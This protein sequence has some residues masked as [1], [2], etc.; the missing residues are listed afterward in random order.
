MV[1]ALQWESIGSRL[2]DLEWY[3]Q[4]LQLLYSCIE[5]TFLHPWSILGMCAKNTFI[6]WWNHFKHNKINTQ[7]QL[8]NMYE[9]ATACIPT[10]TTT[11]QIYKST[12]TYLFKM[13]KSTTVV[14]RSS[15]SSFKSLASF[16][17]IF[18]CDVNFSMI[19]KASWAVHSY[20]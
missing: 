11:I 6:L 14:S 17:K 7:I 12:T 4:L 20:L 1:Y 16:W 2:A 13:E 15:C 3:S 10:N 5:V 18:S 9:L 19:P 8:C